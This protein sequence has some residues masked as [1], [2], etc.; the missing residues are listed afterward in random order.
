MVIFLDTSTLVK[1][2]YKE[3]HSGQIVNPYQKNAMRFFY[4]K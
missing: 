1:L 2:Y 3:L 4:L